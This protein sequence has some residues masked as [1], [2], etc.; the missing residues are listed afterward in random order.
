LAARTGG[1]RPPA[2]PQPLFL[3][4]EAVESPHTLLPTGEINRIVGVT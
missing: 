1:S 3:F 4:R 2:T